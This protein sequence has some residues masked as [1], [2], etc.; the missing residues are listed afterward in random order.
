MHMGSLVPIPSVI[1]MER[2]E[3]PISVDPRD[4]RAAETI[5]L[6]LNMTEGFE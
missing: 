5:S 3:S 4:V 1:W 2:S 6:G